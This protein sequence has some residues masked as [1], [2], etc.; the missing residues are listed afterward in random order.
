MEQFTSHDLRRTAATLAGD[1][2]FDE[3]IISK[4]LDHNKETEQDAVATVTGV[5]V[6]SKFLGK[7]REVFD[8]VAKAV[9][10]IIGNRLQNS[11]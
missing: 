11:G 10:E 3:R 9:R 8:G 7:K 5:Y 6:R 1:L 2:G 4:C